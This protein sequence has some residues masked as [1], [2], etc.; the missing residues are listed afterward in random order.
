MNPEASVQHDP[1][2]H[3]FYLDIEGQ[4]CV[5]DYRL[6]AEDIEDGARIMDLTHTG[7]PTALGGRGLAG[8][9]VEAALAHAREHKLKVRPTCSYVAAYIQRHPEHASLLCDPA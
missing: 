7:V 3:R 6:D 2:A 9:L 8:R 5:I 4:R 1:A